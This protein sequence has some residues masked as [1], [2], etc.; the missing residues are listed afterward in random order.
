MSVKSSRRTKTV[1]LLTQK[2]DI[3]TISIATGLSEEEIKNLEAKMK[4]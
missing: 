1:N 3:N 4:S 2:I